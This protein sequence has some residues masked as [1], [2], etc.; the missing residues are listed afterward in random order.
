M[1]PALRLLARASS[2][3]PRGSAL[4]PLSSA[5]LPPLQ[6]YRRILR[7]HRKVLPPEM[8][9]LGDEYVKSEFKLHKDVDNPVHIVGFLTEWQVY[10][11]KL[12]GNTWRGEKIDQNLID[13]L[14]DQQMGQL[15]ELMKATQNQNDSGS[16][17]NEN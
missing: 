1:R 7:T 8:R 17:E 13:H 14:S 16:G 15:Y 12:E 10:A 2:L 3:S 4:D 11:Q 5:L 9:L 6:L